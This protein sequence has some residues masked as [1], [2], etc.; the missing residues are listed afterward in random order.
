MIFFTCSFL[1]TLIDSCLKIEGSVIA[2][3]RDIKAGFYYLREYNSKAFLRRM[4][5]SSIGSLLACLVILA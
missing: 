4:H 3:E 2:T 5:A 1:M